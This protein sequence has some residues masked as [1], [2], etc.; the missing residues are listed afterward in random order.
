MVIQ[1]E[2]I[3]IWLSHQTQG[4][5]MWQWRHATTGGKLLADLIYSVQLDVYNF[6]AHPEHPQIYSNHSCWFF[7]TYSQDDVMSEISMDI[8][9]GF[10]VEGGNPR[11]WVIWLDNNIYCLN[12]KYLSWFEKIKEVLEAI[13]FAK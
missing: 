11:K 10:E 2:Y 13:D 12:N 6:H 4:L 1:E 7:I 5:P 3:P 9:I 8:L